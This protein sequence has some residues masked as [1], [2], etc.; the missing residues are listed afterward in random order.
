MGQRK[1]AITMLIDLVFIINS[2]GVIDTFYYL[3]IPTFLNTKVKRA[4]V[5]KTDLQ[6]LTSPKISENLISYLAGLLE[7]DGS[8]LTPK[9]LKTPSGSAKIACIQIIFAKKK[10]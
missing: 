9:V 3:F 5:T 10:R 6:K 4:Y 8:F 1:L 2:H 7:G